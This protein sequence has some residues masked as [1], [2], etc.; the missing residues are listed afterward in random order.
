MI[1][2]AFLT[3]WRQTVA[4]ESDAQ[5]EQ[6]LIIS[7]TLVEIF[8][9]PSI[10]EGVRF[11]GGT[12]LYKLYLIPGVR[13]SEDIDLVQIK[14]G[15]IGPLLSAIRGVCDSLFG[16]PKVRRKA[17]GVSLGYTTV[18]EIPP[19]QTLRLKV[20]INSREHFT[21]FPPVDRKYEVRSRWFSG[22]ASIPTYTLEELLATKLRALYQRRKGRD[23]FDLW[24]GFTTG[25]ADPGRVVEAFLQYMRRQGREI[26][27]DQFRQNL[28]AKIVHPG[29]RNDTRALLRP[30]MDYD[31]DR[32]YEYLENNILSRMTVEG[33]IHG[34]AEFQ[35]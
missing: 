25:G 22:R 17:D 1:P 5:V 13:Y 8:G 24:Y 35:R 19:V 7:R 16:P 6:D 23:L 21:V 33:S 34:P 29:F 30:E 14:P 27:A 10:K 15:P 4:W 9:V 20:E 2:R 18:S 3:E 32:A 28:A 12:A 11:R 26:T 31:P